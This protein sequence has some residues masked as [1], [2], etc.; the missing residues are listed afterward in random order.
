MAYPMK[1]SGLMGSDKDMGYKFG[2]ITPN[3]LVNG[4]KTKLMAKESSITQM[5]ISTMVNG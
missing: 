4:K 5:V 1:D 2:L 3:T